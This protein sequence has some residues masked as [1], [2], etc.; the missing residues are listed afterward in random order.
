M[1]WNLNLRIGFNACYIPHPEILLDELE[2][3]RVEIGEIG[4]V[5]NKSYT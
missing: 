2:L 5:N 4:L 3:I 1:R